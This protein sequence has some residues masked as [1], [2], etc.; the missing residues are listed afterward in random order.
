ML[1]RSVSMTALLMLLSACA[2][3]PSGAPQLPPP[4]VRVPLG[5]SFQDRMGDF[6]NG[7]LPAPISSAAPSASATAGSMR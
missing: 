6:L 2:A 5:P 4:P 3:G 1:K 7:K